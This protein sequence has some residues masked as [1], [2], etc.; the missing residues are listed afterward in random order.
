MRT[1]EM[2]SKLLKSLLV[3]LGF[4][5]VG[6]M[7]KEMY[8]VPA[9]EYG[10]PN[11]DFAVKG[12]VSDGL[13][14]P[15]EGIQMVLKPYEETDSEND[16]VY[17]DAAG[18]YEFRQRNRGG[19]FGDF[20]VQVIAEDIDGVE[21][22]GDFAEK[23]QKVKFTKSDFPGSGG[24]WYQGAAEKTVDVELQEKADT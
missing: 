8:G 5:M 14:N 9:A 4:T 23:T 17:T 16:T 18:E 24:N 13:G 21:N 3:M 20:S 19:T 12:Q 11:V 1:P 10:V 22:G 15:I 7:G 2:K 6:C